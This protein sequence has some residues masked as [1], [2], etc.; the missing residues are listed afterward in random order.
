MTTQKERNETHWKKKA[1]KVVIKREFSGDYS[2][3]AN[4]FYFMVSWGFGPPHDIALAA[5]NFNL[6][7]CDSLMLVDADVSEKNIEFGEERAGM[8][9]RPTFRQ[10]KWTYWFIIRNVD[11]EEEISTLLEEENYGEINKIF[12]GKQ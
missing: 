11:L 12:G 3:S 2:E 9:G 7:Y 8:I 1:K 4:Q 10:I 5:N 6:D